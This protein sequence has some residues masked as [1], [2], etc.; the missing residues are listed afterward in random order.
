MSLV[1]VIIPVYNTGKYLYKCFDSIL[2]QTHTN[3]E[4]IV[5]DDNSTDP[6]TLEILQQ[7]QEKYKN[8]KYVINETNL[9]ASGSRNRG[10]DLA[11]GDYF[12]FVDSDDYL[13]PE[14]VET[15]LNAINK[16]NVSY[17]LCNYVDFIE[18]EHDEKEIRVN[19]CNIQ[20]NH[21]YKIKYLLKN[22][23]I[24]KL[25]V[26]PYSRLIPLQRYK[27]SK[28]KF[29]EGSIFEDNDWNIRLA[30][31][32]ESIVYLDYNGYR[33]RILP[34]SIMHSM[35]DSKIKDIITTQYRV[36][37]CLQ[38][39]ESFEKDRNLFF[40]HIVYDCLNQLERFES[41]EYRDNYIKL[42]F[43]HLIKMDFPVD[44][45]NKFNYSSF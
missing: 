40:I 17:V 23:K 21:V 7:Y 25:N 45:I 19:R 1:S 8:F 18:N 4:L 14:F 12:C 16:F 39:V 26:C 32:S 43:E 35:K 30:L 6:L 33:R 36:Y 31:N 42:F 34:S 15:M 28:N 10:I 13:I 41:P 11:K 20:P 29:F 27:E 22:L 24:F 2:H 3:I 37:Q 44:P 5:V 9:G 38:K